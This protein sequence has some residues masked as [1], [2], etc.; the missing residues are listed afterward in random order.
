MKTTTI[1]TKIQNWWRKKVEYVANVQY[2]P[3][4]NMT[5]NPEVLAKVSKA[6]AENG[7]VCK[8]V[9][10]GFNHPILVTVLYLVGISMF[11]LIGL[12]IVAGA[13]YGVAS[14]VDSSI[15]HYEA[16]P[17]VFQEQA[18]AV[19]TVAEANQTEMIQHTVKPSDIVRSI[20]PEKSTPIINDA[21]FSKFMYLLFGLFIVL[22]FLALLPDRFSTWDA[23][24]VW[25]KNKV[26][27]LIH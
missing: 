23:L 10:F 16:N 3:G 11:T 13:T 20:N 19:V 8:G 17:I 4:G 27:A 21:E 2:S 5:P 6:K 15:K 25:A 24:G 7:S 22:P 12:G 26:K 14:H 9:I 1:I 18:K